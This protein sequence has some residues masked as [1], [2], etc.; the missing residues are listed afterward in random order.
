VR[1]DTAT[2]SRPG[3]VLGRWGSFALAALL[4][5]GFNLA[6]VGLLWAVILHS[7]GRGGVLLA[8]GMT[9]A[10]LLTH[11]LLYVAL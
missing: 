9:V 3:A 8:A 5:A 1:R 6:G 7:D 10:A 11:F 2:K 4:P